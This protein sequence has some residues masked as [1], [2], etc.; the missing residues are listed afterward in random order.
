M[1]TVN[2]K[3]II[4]F[5]S[6]LLLF[7]F[8]ANLRTNAYITEIKVSGKTIEIDLTKMPIHTELVNFEN[9]LTDAFNTVII[10]TTS[11]ALSSST[12]AL[13]IFQP[14]F[15]YTTQEMIDIWDFL[16]TGNKT[17]FIGGDSDYGGFFLPTY[18]NALLESLG[19]KIRLDATAISDIV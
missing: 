6:S 17:L 4:L 10:S 18:A 2:K 5:L 7:G 13:V 16:A 9:N 15:V 14:G 19:S 3:L 12:D 8:L 11:L 1:S